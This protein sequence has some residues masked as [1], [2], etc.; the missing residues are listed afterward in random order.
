M[1][2]EEGPKA[3]DIYLDFIITERPSA[4][5]NDPQL[6]LYDRIR[7]HSQ[8]VGFHVGI[9]PKGAWRSDI[10]SQTGESG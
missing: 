7:L 8:I 10:I 4:D 2:C 6:Q 9:C 5:E 1:K 3:T